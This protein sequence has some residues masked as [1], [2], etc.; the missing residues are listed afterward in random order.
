MNKDSD[1]YV[2]ANKERNK[3]LHQKYTA[4]EKYKEKRRLKYINNLEFR[5]RRKE[6]AIDFY[7]DNKEKNKTDLEFKERRKEIAKRSYQK[8]KERERLDKEISAVS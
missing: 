1:E 3:M 6:I 4:T 5:E 7:Y 8:K 2:A